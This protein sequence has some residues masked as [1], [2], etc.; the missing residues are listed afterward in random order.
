M[1]EEIQKLKRIAGESSLDARV[2]FVPFLAHSSALLYIFFT[3]WNKILEFAPSR[4]TY[5]PF[6]CAIIRK[7]YRPL[8]AR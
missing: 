7:F 1:R 3:S 5:V 6:I 2:K 8:K 4:V